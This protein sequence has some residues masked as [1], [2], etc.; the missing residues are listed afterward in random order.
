MNVRLQDDGYSLQNVA[1]RAKSRGR[2]RLASSNAHI[3]P[4]IDCG[5]LSN[6]EDLAT[7][8]N[9][10]KLSRELGKRAEWGDLLGEEIFPGKDVQTDDEIDEYI[11]S[12]LHTANALVGTCKMGTG[13]D[14]VVGPDLKV[15]GVSG[16]RVCDSSIIPQIP[17]GQTGTPTVMVAERA[18]AFILNPEAVVEVMEEPVPQAAV[19]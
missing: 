14:A 18:A 9:G 5:Y 13:K 15:K 16:V 19:A 2:V 11:K 10:I 3:K 4:I 1:C 17:G 8:R 6:K 7:L 12:Y